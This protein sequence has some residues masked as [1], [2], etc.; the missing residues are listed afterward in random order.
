MVGN[1]VGPLYGLHHP[2]YHVLS[3]I[4]EVIVIS[5]CLQQSLVMTLH[6]K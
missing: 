3:Q 1:L 5:I 2:A 6:L 4:H